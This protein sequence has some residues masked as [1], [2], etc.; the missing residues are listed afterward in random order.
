MH[1]PWH[2]AFQALAAHV[3]EEAVCLARACMTTCYLITAE[4]FKLGARVRQPLR[5]HLFARTL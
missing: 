1:T 2:N 3:A 5:M 4:G